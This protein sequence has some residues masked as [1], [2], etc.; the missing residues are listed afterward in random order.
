MVNDQALMMSNFQNAMA[1][2]AVTGQDVSALIDCSDVI[3]Q[4]TPP[5]GVPATYAALLSCASRR[6][7]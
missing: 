6:S 3:P 5:L 2:L 4:A 1:K 7:C